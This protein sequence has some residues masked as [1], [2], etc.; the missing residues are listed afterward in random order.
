VTDTPLLELR[1]VTKE[2]PGGTALA[3]VN[4]VVRHGESHAICGESGAGKSALMRILSGRYPHG[5]YTGEVIYRGTP[6]RFD[7]VRA[8]ER[9]GIVIIGQEPALIPELSI[10]ENLLLGAE[11]R[12]FGVID[13]RATRKRACE[14]LD[15]VGVRI[16]PDAPAREL[17]AAG[18]QLVEIAKA[19]AR[20]VRLLILNEPTAALSEV[21]CRH[22]LQLVRRLNARGIAAIVIANRLK[23]IAQIA[24]RVT[25]LRDGRTVDTLTV[26]DH[27]GDADRIASLRS[28][29]SARSRGLVAAGSL[30]TAAF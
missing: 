5:S 13:W 20:N 8:S 27:D 3:D 24:D 12:Q 6:C 15:E 29:V 1:S 14:L 2:F 11:P 21:E 16:D 9:A 26:P 10:A 25:I 28:I 4:L 17:S 22:L 7:T 19:L 30:L 18:Q 23:E